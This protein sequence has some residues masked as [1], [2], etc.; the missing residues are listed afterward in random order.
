M[1]PQKIKVASNYQVESRIITSDVPGDKYYHPEIVIICRMN[2]GKS[3]EFNFDIN[4]APRIAI[5]IEIIMKR[6]ESEKEEEENFENWL[7][8]RLL[9]M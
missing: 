6:M 7:T 4:V 9:Q 5:A 1:K 2:D 8:S 3:S